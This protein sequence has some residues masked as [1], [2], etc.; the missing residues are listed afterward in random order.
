MVVTLGLT[1]LYP[2]I[3]DLYLCVTEFIVQRQELLKLPHL[4]RYLIAESLRL[5][6]IHLSCLKINTTENFKHLH[7]AA[8]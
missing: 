5:E 3:G 6:C 1:P 2:D 8:L 7:L 4:Q